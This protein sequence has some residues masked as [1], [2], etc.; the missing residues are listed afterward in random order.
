MVAPLAGGG[1]VVKVFGNSAPLTFPPP[2]LFD[3]QAHASPA[4][5]DGITFGT[6]VDGASPVASLYAFDPGFRGGVNLGMGSV[7]AFPV[8]LVRNTAEDG[9]QVYQLP[10]FPTVDAFN[11]IIAGAGP[12]GGP[13]VKVFKNLSTQD[14]ATGAV[15]FGGFSEGDTLADFYAFEPAFRGGVT[16]A[17][18]DQDGDGQGDLVVGAGP[19]G[20]PNVRVFTARTVVTPYSDPFSPQ[21]T[22]GTIPGGSS[23]RTV[24]PR[25][26]Y[27]A[28]VQYGSL[29]TFRTFDG[30]DTAAPFTS[31]YAADPSYAGGVRVDA[32]PGSAAFTSFVVFRSAPEGEVWLDSLGWS[33]TP[34]FGGTI[35]VSFGPGLAAATASF[36]NQPLPA[37]PRVNGFTPLSSSYTRTLTGSVF[38]TGF[39]GGVS[40]ARLGTTRI[41]SIRATQITDSF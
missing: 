4:Q 13:R 41:T 14:Q 28:I 21:S 8:T 33:P 3:L 7:N 23:G 15:T 20:G 12:D 32:S 26:A 38:D 10:E 37:G 2:L 35:T 31:F 40:L 34:A 24:R 6:T 18:A 39:T 5:L 17:F 30:F 19:G 27:V 25:G 16:V 22:D 9:R 36:R 11:D 29:T 1:P